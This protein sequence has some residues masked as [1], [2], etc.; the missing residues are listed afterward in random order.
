[1]STEKRYRIFS[2]NLCAS[3]EIIMTLIFKQYRIFGTAEVPVTINRAGENLPDI[4]IARHD[5]TK[6][7]NS[8]KVE[9][10][11]NKPLFIP[12]GR[13]GRTYKVQ[14]KTFNIIDFNVW[15]TVLG[16]DILK[17]IT[18]TYAEFPVGSYW[19][20]ETFSS[21][22]LPGSAYACMS[23]E[24][25]VSTPRGAQPIIMEYELEVSEST[26]NAIGSPRT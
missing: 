26:S 13:T 8:I 25:N 22:E 11:D 2:R 12:L 6:E 7:I 17:V 24:A 23:D 18:S 21:S 15:S 14:F 20:V 1:M 3:G 5:E 19:N 10:I 16:N 9:I 4:S